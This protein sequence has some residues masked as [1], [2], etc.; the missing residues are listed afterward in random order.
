ML[1]CVHTK[2]PKSSYTKYLMIYIV[3]CTSFDK[4]LPQLSSKHCPNWI[5]VNIL[6]K[7]LRMFFNYE[8]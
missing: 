7:L 3:Q 2:L 1:I 5:H 4:N 8:V 6:H